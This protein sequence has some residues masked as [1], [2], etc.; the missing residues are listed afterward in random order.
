VFLLSA[1]EGGR[2]TPC[3]SGY[4]PQFYFGASDVPGKLTFGEAV[5]GP[6]ERSEV[7]FELGHEVA[8]EVGMRFAMREGGRTVGAGV[9]SSV[10]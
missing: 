6:G 4:T 9:V 2:K 5:L 8:L 1:E 7:T 3:S 10:A